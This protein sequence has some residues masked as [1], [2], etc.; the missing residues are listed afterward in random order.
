MADTENTTPETEQEQLPR[1]MDVD[2]EVTNDAEGLTGTQLALEQKK[3]A[4]EWQKYAAGV[5][6][7]N[8]PTWGNEELKTALQGIVGQDEK[9]GGLLLKSPHSDGGVIKYRGVENRDGT[10]TEQLIYSKQHN[11][12]KK[13]NQRAADDM[14]AAA[15]AMGWKNVDVTGCC[16][17]SKKDMLWLAVQKENMRDLIKHELA[18]GDASTFKPKMQVNNYKGSEKAQKELQEYEEKLREKNGMNQ[19]PGLAP[20][21]NSEPGLTNTDG[22]EQ[23][24]R[25]SKYTNIEEFKKEIKPFKEKGFENLSKK[26]QKQVSS[27]INKGDK[28]IDKQQSDVEKKVQ[29]VYTNKVTGKEGYKAHKE[30]AAQNRAKMEAYKTVKKEEN[31]AKKNG[32]DINTQKKK[33]KNSPTM[34]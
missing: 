30:I 16:L 3:L 4:T 12:G 24:R 23:K 18:G 1:F 27:I 19:D 6:K 15:K 25:L 2:T 5:F 8:N 31:E 29:S 21:D 28:L 33:K 10:Y 11:A 32:I 34:H 9:D 7:D 22:T 13:F 20:A 17:T 26:E 14:V